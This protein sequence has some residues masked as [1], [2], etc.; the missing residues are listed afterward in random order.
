MLSRI[1][2]FI[3]AALVVPLTACTPAEEEADP[4][5]EKAPIAEAHVETMDTP[6]W[7]SDLFRA[8][9]SMDADGFVRFMAEDVFFRAGS[10]EP[11]RGKAAVRDDIGSLFS[12]IKGI[13]HEL[14]DTWV[15][16]NVIVVHGTVTYTRPDETTLTVPFADIWK[17]KDDLI[18][19]YLIFIDNAK[20]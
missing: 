8:V 11:L 18:Q 10:A 12:K 5:V 3:L 14:S 9:D 2:A 19:E 1:P 17:M 16:G 7:V 15:H 6:K 13:N 20:L 4:A